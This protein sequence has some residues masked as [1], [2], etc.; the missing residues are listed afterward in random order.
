MSKHVE[1]LI[2]PLPAGLQQK[3]RP[4][5]LR[6]L[7][8]VSAIAGESAVQLASDILDAGLEK[9]ATEKQITMPADCAFKPVTK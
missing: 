1:N 6:R 2:P 8:V 5:T 9:I 4:L 3:L 7:K